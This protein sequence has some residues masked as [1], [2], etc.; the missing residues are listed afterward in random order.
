[1]PD[2]G[3]QGASLWAKPPTVGRNGVAVAPRA[4]TKGAGYRSYEI[5]QRL[6]VQQSTE[7][8][9]P[10]T[11]VSEAF[12][13]D[14]Y[15]TFEILRD[16]DPCYRDWTGNAYWIS[17]YDDVT[18]V[19]VDDA[20]FETRSKLWF[21]GRD[22]LG[23]DLRAELPV[24]FSQARLTD[25]HAVGVAEALVDGFSR[26]GEADLATDFAARYPLEML[27]RRLDL[28][29]ED[30]DFFADRYWTM[31]RGWGWSPTAERD[32]VQA[33]RDLADHVR[34]I[35]AA[36]RRDPGDDMISAIAA[37]DLED[38]PAT[39]EDVVVTL[40]EGDHETLHGAL[41][42]LWFLLLSHPDQLQ[43]VA[44]DRRL[45]KF[46]YLETLRHS[47]PV[48]TARR[49]TRH[50]VERFGVLIPQ[51][52]LVICAAGAANRDPRIFADPDR[53]M[54]ERKDLCAREPRGQYRADGLPA[55]IAFGLGKPSRY[56][57][58]PEDRPRSLYALTRDT[59]VAAAN[60]ILDR[61]PN[62][63]LKPGAEPA[64]RSLRVGEMHACWRLPV[65]FDAA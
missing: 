28:P 11:L 16:T 58:L 59:A 17:R 7:R 20:N 50:E 48:L 27:A 39:A 61:L 60:V 24:L 38:G 19:F 31:Q 10:S 33:M 22:G 26:E 36:R 21:Y 25:R 54:V 51:G 23:R 9:N 57:A 43:R 2:P 63:R 42:N 47:A 65:L 5:H 62:L 4:V 56:P 64:L 6:R 30:F 55:G 53:F 18:S 35:L 12:V 3:A 14:P 49:F 32:G 40:L 45:V 34:P 29:P 44:A 13:R 52:A 46:A 15:P 41:A 8:L 37:L 1:L